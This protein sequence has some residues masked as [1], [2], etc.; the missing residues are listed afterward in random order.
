[1]VK[2]IWTL[3]VFVALQFVALEYQSHIIKCQ[4]RTI[5]QLMGWI[6]RNGR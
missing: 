6:R 5:R 2:V 3:V 1:M 4:Q